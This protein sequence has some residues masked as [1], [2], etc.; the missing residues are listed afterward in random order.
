MRLVI[1]PGKDGVVYKT[2]DYHKPWTIGVTPDRGDPG[3]DRRADRAARPDPRH[4]DRRLRPRR[5]RG[6]TSAATATG[7]LVRVAR[8][9][10]RDGR[11]AGGVRSRSASQFAI[12][13]SGGLRADLTCPD[14]GHRG[15]LLPGVHAAAVPDHA[16][17]V[18]RRCCRSGTSSSRSSVNGAELKT[19]LENGVSASVAHGRRRRRRAASR[20]CRASAS[21]TT[22][23]LPSAESG[24]RR[25]S[26]WMRPATAPTTPVDLTAG[27]DIPH[28]R[29][30][31]HG[32]RR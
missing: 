12:T 16:R 4:A 7:R 1:G 18:A 14:R 13:N 23:Q 5:S 3:R 32:E 15:R 26:A 27:D 21:P 10:R 24:D 19:M 25:V 30:R 20:R 11:H 29:E 9:Q 8:R 2:A 6:P 31:L 17:P 28:R 22:S